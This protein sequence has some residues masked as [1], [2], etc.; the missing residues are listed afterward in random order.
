[1]ALSGHGA[2]SDL[3][4]LCVPK[5][6]FANATGF[7]SSRP[8]VSSFQACQCLLDFSAAVRA[9]VDELDFRHVPGGAR[10]LLRTWEVLGS[11][12]KR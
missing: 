2:M 3:S 9:L 10:R 7:M 5:R 4:P 11:L 6:T 1:M 8:I 12:G